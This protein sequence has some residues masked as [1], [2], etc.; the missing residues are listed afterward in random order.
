MLKNYYKILGVRRGE[1]GLHAAYRAKA[2]KAHPDT[3]GSDAAFHELQE[4]YKVFS[5]SK[6]RIEYEAQ[7]KKYNTICLRCSGAG[8]T[9]KQMTFTKA[10]IKACELCCGSGYKF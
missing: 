8:Y 7:L 4:A 5:N 10:E 3:G 1:E 6:L 2:A 9:T